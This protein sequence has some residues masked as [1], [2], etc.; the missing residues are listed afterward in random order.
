VGPEAQLLQ[1]GILVDNRRFDE[2]AVILQGLLQEGP[3]VAGAAHALLARL[4]WERE[5]L[6][7]ERVQEIEEHRRQAEELLPQSAEAYFLR[8]MTAPT[9]KEQFAAL[10]EALELDPKHYEAR[11]LRAFTYYASRKY[12]PMSEEAY[13]MQILRDH[14]PLGHSLRAA[15]LRELGRYREALAEY[16]RALSLPGQEEAQYLDLATQR[17]ETLLRMGQ[18]EEVVATAPEAIKRWPERPVFQYQL[19][20]ALTAQ[21]QDEKADGVFREIV[22]RRPTA[23]NEFWFWATKYVFD[24]LEAGRSWHPPDRK[25]VGAAFLPLVEAE[26][27][28]R[29]LSARGRRVIT[30]G[31]SAQ[32]SPDGKKLAFSLGVQGRSGVA[33][34]DPTTK[35]TDLLIVPGK[36]PKWSPDGKYIAFV[37]DRQ[38][39]RVPEFVSPDPKNQLPAGTDEEVWLMNADGTEPRRLVRGVWPSWG[40]DS[41][42]VYYRSRLDSTLYSIP[43]AGEGRPKRIMA[44][45]GFMPSVSPDNQRVAYMEG[46][47]LKVTDLSSQTLVAQWPLPVPSN[48]WGASAW[49]PAGNELCLG[50]SGGLEN[51]TGLWIY[52]LDRRE[53]AQTLDGP[54]TVA[55]WSPDGTK[56]AFELGAPYFGIWTAGLAPA[57]SAV[58]ALGPARTTEQH[59][60]ELVATCTRRIEADP[61]DAYA[62]ADRARY[63]DCLQE[64]TKAD[65]DMRRWSAAMSGRSPSDLRFGVFPDL[66]HVIHLPFDCELVFS[67]ERPFDAIPMMSI[68]FGQKGRWEMKSCKVPMV[69]ISAL[70]FCF[71]SG[72]G[73]PTAHAGFTFGEAVNLGPTVNSSATE[74]SPIIS[75]DGLELYFASNRPGGHGDADIWMT[76]RSSIDD[77]WAPPVNL[78]APINT[79]GW[80][81]PDSI[82]RD[83]LTLYLET[84]QGL[85][86]STRTTKEAP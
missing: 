65:A 16:D 21:G 77:A 8:A 58:E 34:F 28:Y 47:S 61:Q 70:W 18:H 64:R 79:S 73:A 20:C 15:A 69:V 68:A 29:E 78:G 33:V 38:F 56:L 43:I 59:L 80:E 63:Y 46:V 51:R 5:G 22:R 71:L 55:A 60:R 39:L 85:Y 52:R 84:Y 45:P 13:A 27:T 17:L 12:G 72:G 57:V 53:P 86:A 40:R 14:D 32:W 66:R 23:R 44:C 75:P 49:S 82:S 42:C 76:K 62:Y 24:I 54:I 9:I 2:A 19:F 7:A 30:D 11:R 36:Y 6:D 48:G 41:T 81:W 4:L 50:G 37:R 26:E 83:G 3:E 67:A 74:G 35:Q 1:A 25:P 31:F 10:D